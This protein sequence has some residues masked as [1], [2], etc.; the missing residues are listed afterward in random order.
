MKQ[1][2]ITFDNEIQLIFEPDTRVIKSKTDENESDALSVS[3]AVLFNTILYNH[4][5]GI[6]YDDKKLSDVLM[7]SSINTRV[8]NVVGLVNKRFRKPFPSIKNI[9]N[10]S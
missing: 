5:K 7:S 3:E 4:L 1:Y 8:S 6:T 2:E 10:S 9:F